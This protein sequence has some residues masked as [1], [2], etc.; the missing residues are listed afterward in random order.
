MKKLLLPLVC[1]LI[2]A[3]CMSQE[4]TTLYTVTLV[5]CDTVYSQ[6]PVDMIQL[7]DSGAVS[8]SCRNDHWAFV[9]W[10]SDADY[11]ESYDRPDLL[12]GTF[13]PTQDTT[14]YAVYQS[15]AGTF[16]AMQDGVLPEGWTC[17]GGRTQSDN[18]FYFPK[19]KYILSDSCDLYAID[20]ISLTY[21]TETSCSIKFSVSDMD[22]NGGVEVA[23]LNEKSTS[24]ITRAV[25]FDVTR[26]QSESKH[27]LKILN[28]S[29]KP[30]YFQ[31]IV[32]KYKPKYSLSPV[33]SDEPDVTVS[34]TLMNLGR[35]HSS[36]SYT[37]GDVLVLPTDISCSAACVAQGWVFE[38]WS[39]DSVIDGLSECPELINPATFSPRADTV[40]YAVYRQSDYSPFVERKDT[41]QMAIGAV[42]PEGCVL[43]PSDAQT[44]A[45]NK[46]GK[47]SGCTPVSFHSAPI[48]VVSKEKASPV[49][50]YI[51]YLDYSYT[52]K[53][54]T[55]LKRNLQQASSSNDKLCF[56]S[57]ICQDGSMYWNIERQDDDCFVVRCTADPDRILAY[58]R[59]QNQFGC[60]FE[61][62]MDGENFFPATLLALSDD[63]YAANPYLMLSVPDTVVVTVVADD[64][65]LVDE[66]NV[67]VSHKGVGRIVHTAPIVSENGMTVD[68]V[69]S[70]SREFVFG[71][72]FDCG[73]DDVVVVSGHDTLQ[74]GPDWYISE[75]QPE[76]APDSVGIKA[77][78]VRADS[79]GLLR[80]GIGYKIIL[81]SGAADAVAR[82]VCRQSVVF[83]PMSPVSVSFGRLAEPGLAGSENPAQIG[84][85]YVT[86]PYLDNYS[87]GAVIFDGNSIL[88]MVSVP[89]GGK[90]NQLTMFE[91]QE[92][93]LIVPC[94]PFLIQTATDVDIVFNPHVNA[95]IPD[96]VYR[97]KLHVSSDIGFDSTIVEYRSDRTDAYEVGS[98]LMKLLADTTAIAVYTIND[99]VSLCVNSRNVELP[100]TVPVGIYSPQEKVVTF[101]LNTEFDTAFGSVYLK[102]NGTFVPLQ[103][104]YATTVASGVTD[105]RFAL[106]F[107]SSVTTSDYVPTGDSS[108]IS[109][110]LQDDLLV[111]YGI[112]EGSSVVVTDVAGRIVAE[113]KGTDGRDPLSI[114][115]PVRGVYIVSVVDGANKQSEKILY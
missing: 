80:K 75:F 9:G 14:L 88:D 43:L 82:F 71:L 72:P 83:D 35:L 94:K 52:I 113:C 54:I 106:Y 7:P 44:I 92:C 101:T 76:V 64:D 11:A 16:M 37:T 107:K 32:L 46:S 48:C 78:W 8:F 50:W 77:G 103:D 111:V 66:L 6:T 19:D 26:R 53:D 109:Y 20:S 104:G 89:D 69:F 93:S 95:P 51:K 27:H 28:F 36:L 47:I 90:F 58:D 56:D 67:T 3:N 21:R 70:D 42:I 17:L 30:L 23:T 110:R 55:L 31:T 22:G 39:A 10:T 13:I 65:Y 33:C 112:Y 40:L 5:N 34:V 38:G 74:Y 25:K 59:Q 85:R 91:A 24:Y 12:A 79:I 61:T 29:V 97:L 100:L 4:E 105:D 102:D 86:S 114:L 41:N 49:S 68:I 15:E 63:R 73:V 60:F 18:C 57:Y 45:Y 1:C 2:A 99:G 62:D 84:W 87:Q 108:C 96:P 115:L 81:L 98:D